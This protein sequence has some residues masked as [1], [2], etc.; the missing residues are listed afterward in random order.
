MDNRRYVKRVWR[1]P[2]HRGAL[3]YFGTI[4]LKA[5]VKHG[6]PAKLQLDPE[7]EGFLIA[8]VDQ[9]GAL[10]PDFERAFHIAVRIASRT[11]GV[12]TTLYGNWCGL[13]RL[14]RVTEGGHFREI[15]Q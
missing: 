15:E 13:D 14:Y 12:E 8:H 11:Y 6:W 4:V 1:V 2:K 3:E 7:T 5:L 9:S 10:P